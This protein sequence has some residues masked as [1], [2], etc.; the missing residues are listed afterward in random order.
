MH[1]N[2]YGT[3]NV[4]HCTYIENIL[5]SIHNCLC[6][7]LISI[8]TATIKSANSK[9]YIQN[10]ER[11]WMHVWISRTYIVS[12]TK[13]HRVSYKTAEYWALYVWKIQ[14]PHVLAMIRAAQVFSQR[15]TELQYAMCTYGIKSCNAF[16]L[17]FILSESILYNKL[18]SRVCVPSSSSPMSLPH[19]KMLLVVCIV[20]LKNAIK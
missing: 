17:H 15:Y 16:I 2:F 13:I 7:M 12:H 4:M 8:C 10:V 19:S 14:K 5:L 3:F 1:N 6:S 9:K 18:F 11:E 20:T